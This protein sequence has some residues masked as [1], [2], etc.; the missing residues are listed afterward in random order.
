MIG[1]TAGRARVYSTQ[2]Q[3]V[4]IYNLKD[5]KT[6]IYPCVWTRTDMLSK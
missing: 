5:N 3:D 6:G 1:L 4:C 2:D